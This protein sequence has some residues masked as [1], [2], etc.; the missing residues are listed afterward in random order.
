[1]LFSPFQNNYPLRGGVME[2]REAN[3]K[4]AGKLAR[5]HVLSPPKPP[6]LAQNVWSPST[7]SPC[8]IQFNN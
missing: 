6:N 5:L 7:A 1:M 8:L 4:N 3:T 2:I